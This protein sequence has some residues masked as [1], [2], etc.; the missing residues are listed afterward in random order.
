ML[1]PH[2]SVVFKDCKVKSK[3]QAWMFAHFLLVPVR[4]CHVWAL[5]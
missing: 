2:V 5:P 3:K 4:C 1:F